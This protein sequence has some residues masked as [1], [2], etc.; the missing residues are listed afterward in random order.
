M[1]NRTSYKI[2]SGDTLSAIAQRY[3][4]S[5]NRWREITKDTGE[6]F[7]EYEARRL[8][9]GQVVNFPSDNN[10]KNTTL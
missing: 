9:I 10:K 5:V 2:K 7:T 8:Q 6:C 1:K 3:L 4:G